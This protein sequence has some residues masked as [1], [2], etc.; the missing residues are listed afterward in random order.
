[1]KYLELKRE[2]R[3]NIFTFLD[4]VKHFPHENSQ[5]VRVQLARFVQKGLATRIKRGL[6]CFDEKK[7]DELDLA[8]RLYQPSYISLEAALNFYGIIPDIPQTVTSVTLTTTKRI[9]N[10]FGTFSYTKIKPQLYFGFAKVKSA[11]TGAFFNLAKKEK[12]LLD[13]FYLRKIKSTKDLRLNLKDLDKD[14]Y[15][16]YASSYP[17][18]VQKII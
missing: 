16:Q 7:I 3:G 18:W 15:Q 10:Q 2:I 5:T 12:A 11:T 13:Y 14:S 6:Y 9:Q 4:V 1:M 17:D 8:G